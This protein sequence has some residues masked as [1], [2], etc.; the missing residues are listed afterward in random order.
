MAVRV[1]EV[2]IPQMREPI[3]IAFPFV[4]DSVGGSHMSALHLIRNLDPRKYRPLVILHRDDGPVATLFK[5][6]KIPYEMAPVSRFLEGGP[7]DVLFLLRDLRRMQAFLRKRKVKLLHTND[8][9]MH[10]TWQL[11][12]RLAGVKCLWHHRGNPD[13]F[14]LCNMAPWTADHVVAV[15]RFSSPKGRHW[16]EKNC[17][18]VHSPFDLDQISAD[19]AASRKMLIDE[20]G[21]PED[22]VL[23]GYF[24]SL[25]DRKRPVTFAEIT[26]ALARRAKPR[27]VYGVLFGEGDADITAA[28]RR[29]IAELEADDIVRLMG[30]RY[31]PTPWMAACDF[32][33][34]PA[35]KEPLGRTLVEAMLLK[36]VVIA[37]D[38][39]GSP[40][41][42]ENGVTGFI[43]PPDQP[44]AFAERACQLLDD[45][46]LRR[47]ITDRA[48]SEAVRRFGLDVH[49]KS[50]SRIYEQL[51]AA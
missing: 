8:G 37:A 3:V 42:I 26:A 6:E 17:S 35:I 45:P 11:A 27:P 4:G 14:G 29:R 23:I 10:V 20:L 34:V 46:A 48:H 33:M 24:G 1:N 41:A 15:S 43:V 28:V 7:G 12:G 30:F 40:E 36:T 44:E 51:I 5:R 21:C 13:A 38:S 32:L 49:V 47:R 18:V 16:S 19:R 22:T 2:D 9:R 25:V 50:I 31:P 39:G